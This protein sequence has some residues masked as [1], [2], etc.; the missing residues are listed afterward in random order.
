MARPL[1]IEFEGALYHITSRGNA[2]QPIYLDDV[3]RRRFFDTL[4]HVVSRHEW[5]CHAYGSRG[6]AN[7]V[8]P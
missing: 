4:A 2:L 7:A 5:I 8:R 3:D 6:Q 1:R